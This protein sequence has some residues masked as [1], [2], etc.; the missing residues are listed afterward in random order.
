ME[1]TAKPKDSQALAWQDGIGT[2]KST[3]PLPGVHSSFCHEPRLSQ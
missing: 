3:P 1:S 2:F